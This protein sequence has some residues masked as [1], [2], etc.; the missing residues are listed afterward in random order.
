MHYSN[1]YSIRL[2]QS[3]SLTNVVT[4]RSLSCESVRLAD[5][6]L[7]IV[8]C[9]SNVRHTLTGSEYPT[10]RADC[11]AAANAMGKPSLREATL[12]DVEGM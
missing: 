8:V 12:A 9:N 11:H 7:S 3:L 2:L 5:E 1:E 10:R 4:I 6:S